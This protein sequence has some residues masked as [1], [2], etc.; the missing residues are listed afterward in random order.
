M[1]SFRISAQVPQWQ[2]KGGSIEKAVRSAIRR[3]FNG[4]KQDINRKVKE[5]Y[6][7]KGGEVKSTIRTYVSG[8]SGYLESTGKPIGLEKF[9]IRPK[10]RPRR[11]P[12]TGTFA[13]VV[14][15]QGDYLRQAWIRNG[16]V[17]ERRTRKRFP[18]KRFYGPSE[19]GMLSSLPMS[20]FIESKINE[21]LNKNLDHEIAAAVLGFLDG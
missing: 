7:V 16:R 5:R 13:Q 6:T 4:L 10:K 11:M 20:S 1:I 3:I 17:Y 21:R 9:Q 19:P 12:A 2:V 15:G 18:I 14:R 8:L